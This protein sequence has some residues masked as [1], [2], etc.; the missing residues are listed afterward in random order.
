[1]LS[2]LLLSAIGCTT[3]KE[4]HTA[5]TGIEQL[6]ISSATDRAL[7]KVDFRPIAGAKVMLDTKYLDCV[8]KNYVI[9]SLRKH[10]LSNQCTLVEKPEDAQVIME[11]ASGGVGTDGTETF[12]GV[13][14][15]P[16]PPPSPI[17]IPK[18]PLVE[19]NRSIGTAKLAL[20][21]Y[22]TAT[23]QLV[24][25]SGYVLARADH[26][27]WSILGLGGI[28]SGN[29]HNELLQH[30]GDLDS[31]TGLATEMASLPTERR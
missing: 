25:N 31:V 9:V 22:D 18:L 16:L 12:V 5:R 28:T 17:A 23:R 7:N 20:V 21:A 15:I 1:M 4:S 2:G 10:L 13:P 8:D 11:V 26:K 14:E 19:R 27:S 24:I 3:M 29:V 6:L 30:T